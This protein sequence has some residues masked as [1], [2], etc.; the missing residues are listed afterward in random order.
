[1]LEVERKPVLIVQIKRRLDA[2]RVCIVVNLLKLNR[3]EANG[4]GSGCAI[5]GSIIDGR[6]AKNSTS[7]RKCDELNPSY[8]CI[9]SF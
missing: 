7:D 1:M 9:V 4:L 5:N 6:G 3:C 8:T 2:T